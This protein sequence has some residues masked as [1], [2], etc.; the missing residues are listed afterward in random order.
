MKCSSVHGSQN[1]RRTGVPDAV[2][3]HRVLILSGRDPTL[4]DSPYTRS[5]YTR[6][7]HVVVV[8]QPCVVTCK[9][10]RVSL[11]ATYTLS[12]NHHP[13]RLKKK[14]LHVDSRNIFGAANPAVF[15]CDMKSNY[16]L[17]RLILVTLARWKSINIITAHY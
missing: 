9:K 17:K 15:T 7:F 16:G 8:K 14:C 3:H 12:G 11:C 10:R 2:I 6:T 5:A 1:T 13:T 4:N